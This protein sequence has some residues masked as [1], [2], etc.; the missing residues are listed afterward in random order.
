M[1]KFPLRYKN[2]SFINI[3][4]PKKGEAAVAALNL[5]KITSIMMSC[6][7]TPLDIRIYV[8]DAHCSH[9]S[10]AGSLFNPITMK[11][12]KNKKTK[13]ELE[14]GKRMRKKK[15][16]QEQQQRQPQQKPSKHIRIYSHIYIHFASNMS[17]LLNLRD[18]TLLIYFFC[19]RCLSH[20]PAH[21]VFAR[22]FVV[23]PT[24]LSF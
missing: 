14:R 24:S 15:I 3:D 18:F 20:P 7:F 23:W 12:D 8:C 11:K 9:H 13:L 17:L 1:C 2:V 6:A 5:I 16:Q 4:Y 21:C 10:C 19:F 22:L